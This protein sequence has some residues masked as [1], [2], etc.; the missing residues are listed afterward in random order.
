M[1][2]CSCQFGYVAFSV[3]LLSTSPLLGSDPL[4]LLQSFRSASL[5]AFFL[6]G[7]SSAASELLIRALEHGVH[8]L[9]VA[10]DTLPP[11]VIV[12]LVYRVT[13]MYLATRVLLVLEQQS[14]DRNHVS[15]KPPP[16]WALQEEQGQLSELL[17][18]AKEPDTASVAPPA[19]PGPAPPTAVDAP[20]PPGAAADAP[21]KAERAPDA[22]AHDAAPT[23]APAA[24]AVARRPDGV[25]PAKKD[26]RPS[27]TSSC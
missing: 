5:P 7:S 14:R 18:M 19:E 3:Y 27:R 25:D 1:C 22:T 23:A 2:A 20:A 12:S 9:T 6:H 8:V 16:T 21:A 26:A 10:L 13:V 24:P 15:S 11:T 17:R 4:H